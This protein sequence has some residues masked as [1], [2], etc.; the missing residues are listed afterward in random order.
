MKKIILVLIILIFITSI[1]IIYTMFDIRAKYIEKKLKE[2]NHCEIKA[3]CILLGNKCPFGCAIYVNKG[4][5]EE[6]RNMFESYSS[7]CAFEC[8]SISGVECINN[9]CKSQVEG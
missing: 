4:N 7:K 5:Y 2:G 9:E 1:F 3:D 6:L 8:P